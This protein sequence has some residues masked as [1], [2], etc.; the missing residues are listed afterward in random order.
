M[1]KKRTF[2]FLEPVG[3]LSLRVRDIDVKV[4][5]QYVMS[6]QCIANTSFNL[7]VPVPGTSRTT[8]RF[9]EILVTK[10]AEKVP[11]RSLAY[12][13]LHNSSKSCKRV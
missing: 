12:H 11:C 8:P 2:C 1:F 13:M 7:P 4:D 9:R 10:L 5:V 6:G 3:L